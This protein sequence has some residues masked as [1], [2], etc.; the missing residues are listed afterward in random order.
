MALKY[1]PEPAEPM[2]TF[3]PFRSSTDLMSGLQVTS[4]TVSVYSAHRAVKLSMGLPS[5]CSKRMPL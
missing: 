2:D 1:T 5:Y 3:L 4:C